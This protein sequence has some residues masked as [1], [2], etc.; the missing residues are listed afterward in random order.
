MIPQINN[1]IFYTKI[2]NR[3][4]LISDSCFIAETFSNA[5]IVPANREYTIHVTHR[6]YGN[7][8][9][10]YTVSSRDFDDFFSRDYD[11][12]FGRKTTEN[13][14]LTGTLVLVDRNVG[15][16]HLISVSVSLENLLTGGTMEMQLYS[17]VPT[18]NLKTLF[19]K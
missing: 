7:Q 19:G 9:K 18:H 2:D 5:L 4:S 12:Y 10:Q 17:N 6:M 13:G 1:D 11:R 3:Y 8:Q 15:C 14:K 16:F